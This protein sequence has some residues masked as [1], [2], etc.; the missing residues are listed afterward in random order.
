M[1]RSAPDLAAATAAVVTIATISPIRPFRKPEDLSR[2]FL[3]RQ[4]GTA[5][6]RQGAFETVEE[7][8]ELLVIAPSRRRE[9]FEAAR[10]FVGRVDEIVDRDL[11]DQNRRYVELTADPSQERQHRLHV[12]RSAAQRVVEFVENQ[13][14]GFQA[15]K[16]MIDLL[17][18]AADV[19][20]VSRR[21]A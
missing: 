10:H 11:A 8:E 5:R 13:D 7:R 18:L 12:A 3:F 9:Q 15:V 6:E 1:I 20:A 16:Q 19:P 2:Q 17:G 21:R 14:L 4:I